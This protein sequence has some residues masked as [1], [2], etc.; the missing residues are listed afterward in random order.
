MAMDHVPSSLMECTMKRLARRVLEAD[1]VNGVM[2]GFRIAS[3][4]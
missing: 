2:V 3:G 4:D 1:Y